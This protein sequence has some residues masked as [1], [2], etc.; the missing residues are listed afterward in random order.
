MKTAEYGKGNAKVIVLLHGGGLSWWNYEETAKILAESYH[1]VLP[2]LDGHAG[3]D[4]PFTTIEDNAK[5]VIAFI[6]E[7]YGGHVHLL[8]GLSL[9]GQIATEVLSQRSQICDFAVIES[10]LA[11]PMPVTAALV[12]PAFSL[13]Y[14]LIRMRWFSRLQCWSLGIRMT[15]FEAYYRDTSCIEKADLIAFMTANAAYRLRNTLAQC[16]AKTLVLV[17]GRERRI[18]K[19]SAHMICKCLPSA[20]LEVLRGLK[21]GELSINHGCRFAQML[22]EW[23][24][25]SDG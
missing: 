1:V 20:R 19:R 14:P 25:S 24:Q 8:G 11:C 21:H 12:K 16:R 17:G 22:L 7:N 18:M 5:R 2:I 6:D 13:C 9:G 15:L 3:S 4:A 23:M 10:A